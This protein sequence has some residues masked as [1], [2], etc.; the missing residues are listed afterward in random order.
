[1]LIL[2]EIKKLLLSFWLWVFI[3]LCIIFNM[4]NFISEAP[5]ENSKPFNIFEGYTTNYIA[6]AHIEALALERG[7]II[8]RAIRKQYARLQPVV[9]QKAT[10]GDAYGQYTGIQHWLIFERAVMPLVFQGI[11]MATLIMMLALGSEHIARTEL[12]IYSAKTGRR[13]I[14]HKL[15]AALVV[16]IFAYGILVI[17][18]FIPV[19][20]AYGDLWG[21]NVSSVFNQVN[22]IFTG[23]RPFITWRSYTVL[24]YFWAV[25]GVSLS[26]MLCFVGAAFVVGTS[27]R[28]SYIG[29][30][31]VLLVSLL[32]VSIVFATPWWSPLRFVMFYTPA[33][34]PLLLPSWFTD[35]KINIVVPHFE[36]VGVVVSLVAL[37]PLV[38]LSAQRFKKR[39]IL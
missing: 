10:E 14:W 9:E 31:T 6:K 38:L 18:T 20:T 25:M 32:S 28:N 29:V 4:W 2:Y 26:L 39:D 36:R 27:I 12:S 1:M 13:I 16:T 19:H 8:E 11:I 15:V 24:G 35:G 3:A 34:L 33:T 23:P 37:L 5:R 22:D 17:T 30:M 7:Q 21:Y